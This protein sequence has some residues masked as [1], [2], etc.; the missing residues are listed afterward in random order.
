MIART[1]KLDDE[2]NKRFCEYCEKFGYS[3]VGLIRTLI[4]NRLDE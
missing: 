3:Q 2:L 4:R 1:V